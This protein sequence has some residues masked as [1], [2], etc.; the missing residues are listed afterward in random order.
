MEE[1]AVVAAVGAKAGSVWL[2]AG[3][4]LLAALVGYAILRAARSRKNLPPVVDTA[5]PYV[6]GLL[7][8]IK[9]PV[10]L[11]R[12]QYGRLGSV[13]TVKILTRNIT[14]LVGPEVSAHFFKAQESD[15]S[16][17]EVVNNVVTASRV[18]M[19]FFCCMCPSMTSIDS[20]RLSG[21]SPSLAE[22]NVRCI[23]VASGCTR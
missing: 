6:G 15:L 16:Q 13:F 5:V 20:V 9:G 10:V 17:R 4:L 21:G 3:T 11:L 2:F 7:K 14:F 12:E 1:E 18:M 8:F 22:N 19:F 23:V